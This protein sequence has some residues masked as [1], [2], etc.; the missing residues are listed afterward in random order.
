MKTRQFYNGLVLM[1]STTLLQSNILPAQ[2]NDHIFPPAK[3]AA[4]YSNFDEKGFIINGKRTYIV[5]AGLEYARI[6]HELWHDRLLKLKR[7]GFNCIEIYTFWNFH[8]PQE[9]KF[10]FSGDHDL[11]TFLK[12]VKALDMYAIVRVGP[13]YCAE[14]DFGGYPIW[15]RFKDSLSVRAPNAAF[16]TYT[17][18]F[19]DKLLPIVRDNQVNHG[20]AVILVQLE[21]EHPAGWGTA[22]PN[23]YF[24]FLQQKALSAG[25]E[26]PYFFSGLHHASDPAGNQTSFDNSLRPN[27]W[28]ST[29]FWS[30]WYNYYGSSQKDAETYGRRT[31]KAIA[32]G[33]GGYNFYMAHGGSNFGY[34]NNNEDAAS[35]DYG[36]AV[37]QTGD[38]RSVYYQ[39]K[40]NALFARSFQ[41]ILANSSD[42]GGA[43][44]NIVDNL[45]ELHV[46]TRHSN[47]G[48]I[49]FIDNRT[50]HSVSTKLSA[51]GQK[52]V[53]GNLVLAPGE[54]FPVVKNFN[55]SN[56]VTI[57]FTAARILGVQKNDSKTTTIVTYGAEGSSGSIYFK[58]NKVTVLIQPRNVHA[59]VGDKNIVLGLTFAK[60]PHVYKL[61]CGD[62]IIRVLALSTEL[63][64]RTW[65]AET[66]GKNYVITGPEY[67]GDFS[68]ADNKFVISTEHF[69]KEQSVYPTNIYGDKDY[70]FVNKDNKNKTG[71]LVLNAWQYKDA[72][73]AAAISF[74]DGKWKKSS[75]ALQMGADGDLTAD[76]WYRTSVDIQEEKKY[77]IK[78]PAGGDR[79]TLFVDNVKTA[80]V[81]IR[82]E[83]LTVQLK[84]GKHLF[85][86]FA[87][88]DGRDKLFNHLGPV[89]EVDAKGL[90]GNITM[91]KGEGGY[92][93]DWK[94]IKASGNTD[95]LPLSFENAMSY[96]SGDDAF[97][98]KRGFAWF[99]ANFNASQEYMPEQLRFKS[100]DDNAIVFVNGQKVTEHKGYGVAFSVPLKGIVKDGSNDVTVLIENTDGA[101]GVDKPVEIVY[102][103]NHEIALTNWSMK[104]GPG[105]FSTNE[106]WKSLSADANFDRPVFYK[107]TFTLNNSDTS[108]KAM[109]RVSLDGLGHGSIWVNGHNLGR[110][111]EKIPVNSMYIPECWLKKGS[112]EIVVYDEDGRSPSGIRIQPEKASSR[113]VSRLVIA[114]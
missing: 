75:V 60:E 33:A 100:V 43:S 97:S 88:H 19:F 71:D 67:L 29:E 99:K 65:F 69:W 55:L 51:D 27:P 5:S 20:G 6:P 41:D 39:N 112:N 66:K 74:D 105:D 49:V 32:G 110:Y 113:N 30:V 2:S 14:W 15:L 98:G 101:G 108:I 8:E 22:I 102:N 104:G 26:V 62:E 61:K 68:I 78:I 9:G 72:S 81:K 91:R 64:D 80:S 10:E 36:A 79:V 84:P 53:P 89:N 44:K 21:N 82:E 56:N 42:G 106:D 59:I 107:N 86:F 70:T 1:L 11:N 114:R 50:S 18:R 16:E 87:A 3:A 96:K 76:A 57:A 46:H 38:L 85:A 92:I 77:T 17:G 58:N 13:Y 35:Y 40:R 7:A 12:E 25:I 54:I 111:P 73:N 63:A 45:E 52:E 94:A 47:V 109:Y 24:T 34:T 4:S 28:F 95:S 37:G 93:R 23:S 83:D 31:W 48:D 103:S 90:S